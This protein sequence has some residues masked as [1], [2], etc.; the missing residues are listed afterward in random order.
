M[1]SM[2]KNILRRRNLCLLR[3][4]LRRRPR[5]K[6]RKSR[7][8]LARIAQFRKWETGRFRNNIF[9]ALFRFEKADAVR[10]AALLI[11]RD[12]IRCSRGHVTSPTIA[13]SVL[14]LRLS[15]AATYPVLAKIL[16]FRS[17][18]W[19]SEVYV[20]TLKRVFC[21]AAYLKHRMTML[22][23][24]AVSAARIERQAG[25]NLSGKIVGF[26]DGTFQSCRRPV[27]GQ[28]SLYSGYKKMHG[29][30]YLAVTG[31]DGLI[32]WLDGPYQGRLSDTAIVA[33]GP[34]LRNI[35]RRLSCLW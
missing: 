7:V 17:V 35:P 18:G 33:R 29:L 26:I 16:N 3:L 11:G 4:A 25:L 30:Q 14:L 22:E 20:E 12:P 13:M 15:T 2:L 23:E 31:P 19:I 1:I 24:P 5:A 28:R 10:L 27:R 9:R 6:S 34:G 8:S 32:G 21:K